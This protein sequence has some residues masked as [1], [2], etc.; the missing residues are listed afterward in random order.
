VPTIGL[1]IASL[2]E[3]AIRRSLARSR[4]ADWIERMRT[5]PVAVRD[6]I[7]ISSLMEDVRD[8]LGR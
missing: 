4:N 2:A 8:E 7:D 6:D 5:R 3:E 1:P